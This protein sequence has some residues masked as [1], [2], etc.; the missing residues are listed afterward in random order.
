MKNTDKITMT[1]GQLK[2]LIK[3]SLEMFTYLV[4]YINNQPGIDN[5]DKPKQITVDA[6]NMKQALDDFLQDVDYTEILKIEKL[7]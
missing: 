4:V 2:R 3:E 1:V 6:K 5:G 7:Y